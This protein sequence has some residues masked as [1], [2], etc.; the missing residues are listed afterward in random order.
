M[1]GSLAAIDQWVDAM[2][3]LS[4]EDNNN[5]NNNL[6][7]GLDSGEDEDDLEIKS[8]YKQK[9]II[10]KDKPQ[11]ILSREQI[12]SMVIYFMYKKYKKFV[13]II[14]FICFIVLRGC[15]K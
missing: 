4:D 5:R 12:L 9:K 14:I 6:N 3:S 11:G 8:Y 13:L 2:D 7:R 15:N 10:S 1:K